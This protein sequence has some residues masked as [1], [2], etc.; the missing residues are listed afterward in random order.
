MNKIF[1]ILACGLLVTAE[2]GIIMIVLQGNHLALDI[3]MGSI[4]SLVL[5][6]LAYLVI[7][8]EEL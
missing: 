7:N 6:A 8:I 1:K 3:T 2:I 4:V 5:L